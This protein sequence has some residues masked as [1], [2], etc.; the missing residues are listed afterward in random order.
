MVAVTGHYISFTSWRDHPRRGGRSR[1]GHR[2][3]AV[4]LRHRRTAGDAAGSPAAGPSPTSRG[5]QL[6]GGLYVTQLV[7]TVLTF[8]RLPAVATA[9]SGSSPSHCGA[10]SPTRCRRCSVRG[11]A[12]RRRRSRR[13]VG[14]VHGGV[15]GRHHGRLVRR[16]AVL[17]HGVLA[18]FAASAALIGSGGRNDRTRGSSSTSAGPSRRYEQNR[19]SAACVGRVIRTVCGDRWIMGGPPLLHTG[20]RP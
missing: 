17:E 10:D 15:S 9:W 16:R 4:D 14:P 6:H 19:S 5:D 2:L 13:R 11:D 7:L 1:P 8:H 20:L 18:M 3:A 12:R